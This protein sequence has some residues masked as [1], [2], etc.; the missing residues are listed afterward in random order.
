MSLWGK[1][2]S[3]S[4]IALKATDATGMLTLAHRL[5][6]ADENGSERRTSCE[7]RAANLRRLLRRQL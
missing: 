3:I 6:E 1:T 5:H 2:S 7:G 4:D